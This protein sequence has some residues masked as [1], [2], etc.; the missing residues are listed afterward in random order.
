MIPYNYGFGFEPNDYSQID[1]Q[2]D[3]KRLG[4]NCKAL[5]KKVRRKAKR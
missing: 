1:L 4:R 3:F 2:I 5:V